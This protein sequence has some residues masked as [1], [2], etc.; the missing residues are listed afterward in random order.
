MNGEKTVFSALI[1]KRVQVSKLLT[2]ARGF[3]KSQR[4]RVTLNPLR[5]TFHRP[6]FFHFLYII[7]Q[8]WYF[9]FETVLQ[10]SQSPKVTSEVSAGG[11]FSSTHSQNVTSWRKHPYKVSENVINSLPPL[12][13][14]LHSAKLSFNVQFFEY[15]DI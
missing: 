10:I 11:H 3:S 6:F 12:G 9:Y 7:L 2:H 13:C 4:L 1:S 5:K 8:K 15:S 14:T